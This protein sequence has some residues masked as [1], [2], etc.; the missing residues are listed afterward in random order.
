MGIRFEAWRRWPNGVNEPDSQDSAAALKAL[1]DGSQP[2]LRV[3]PGQDEE[4]D[5]VEV[6]VAEV[7]E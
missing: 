1:L 6:L 4:P 5:A 7:A 3:V 2:P